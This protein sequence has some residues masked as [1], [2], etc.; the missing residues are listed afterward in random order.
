MGPTALW[1]V[2]QGLVGEAVG[3]FEVVGG[4][5]A[6][7]EE[8]LLVMNEPHWNSTQQIKLYSSSVNDRAPALYA[9]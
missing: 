2:F 7:R 3:R 9:N 4:L 5:R 8:T 1:A 6:V